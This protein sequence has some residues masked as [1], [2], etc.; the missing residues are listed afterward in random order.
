[1]M[2]RPDRLSR[3][4]DAVLHLLDRQ[5]IDRDGLFAGK[6]DDLE[7]TE[8][9]DRTLRLTA[10]LVGPP[11]LLPRLGGRL[12][13]WLLDMWRELGVTRADRDAPGRIDLADVEHLGSGVTLNRPRAALVRT[14][15]EP[16]P[17]TVRR[18]LG[19]LLGMEV[20]GAAG[21]RVRGRVNDLRVASG[22]PPGTRSGRYVVARSLVVSRGRPGSLLG[23][24]RA[25]VSRPMLING[26]IGWLHRHT[27]ELDLADVA[28]IDWDARV[29]HA[30]AEPGPLRAEGERG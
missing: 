12:G 20:R 22:R 27:G 18:R 9:D 15:G 6:V 8:Y 24:D 26:V 10:L 13:G 21:L 3:P 16:M 11:A 25:S 23:Y 29:V 17:G 1:M 2:D 5:I 7:L 28:R 4:M 19:D 30:T 14:Q